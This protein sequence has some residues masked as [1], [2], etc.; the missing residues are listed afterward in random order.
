MADRETTVRLTVEVDKVIVPSGTLQLNATLNLAPAGAGAA[1]KATDS[2]RKKLE[3]MLAPI[4]GQTIAARIGQTFS[5]I[6]AGSAEVSGS[7][8]AVGTASRAC[9]LGFLA[10]AAIVA[11][12]IAVWKYFNWC[13]ETGLRLLTALYNVCKRVA[14]G[15]WNVNRAIVGYIAIPFRAAITGSVQ[16]LEWLVTSGIRATQAVAGLSMEMLKTATTVGAE[17]EQQVANTTTAMGTFGAAGMAMREKIAAAAVAMTAFTATLPTAAAESMWDVASAGFSKFSDLVNV[18]SAAITLAN[19]TLE[20]VSDTGRI[21][22]SILNQYSLATDQAMRVTNALAAA[23]SFSATSVSQLIESMKYAGPIAAAFGMSIEATLA[24]LGVFAQQGILGSQAG[25]ALRNL[26]SNLSAG[27]DKAEKAFRNALGGARALEDTMTA[28]DRAMGKGAMEKIVEQYQEFGAVTGDQAAALA[29]LGINVEDVVKKYESLINLGLDPVAIVELRQ[30]LRG[31]GMDMKSINPAFHSLVEIVQVFEKLQAKLGKQ[32]TVA[33]IGKALNLRAASALYALLNQGSKA[34]ID[35]ERR[36]TGTNMAVQMQRDQLMTLQGQWKILLNLWEVAQ[37]MMAGGMKGALG[38]VVGWLQRLLQTVGQAGMFQRFGQIA[39][40]AIMAIARPLSQL[41]GPA[42]LAVQRI[43]EVFASS[44]PYIEDALWGVVPVMQNFIGQLPALAQTVLASLVN[45]GSW[46]LSVGVPLFTNWVTTV[47]PLLAAGFVNLG[48]TLALFLSQNSGQIIQWF[49]DLLNFGVLLIQFLPSFLPLIYDA[50][51]AFLRWGTEIRNMLLQETGGNF[52]G[53]LVTVRDVLWA[54]LPNIDKFVMTYLPILRAELEALG[55]IGIKFATDTF[56]KIVAAFEKMQPG[57]IELIESITTAVKQ[58]LDA[59]GSFATAMG[60]RFPQIVAALKPIIEWIGNNALPLLKLFVDLLGRKVQLGAID[61]V[62]QLVGL[63]KIGDAKDILGLLVGAG[64]A[65][66]L[67]GEGAASMPP[68]GGA[69]PRLRNMPQEEAISHSEKQSRD[70]YA[71]GDL[72]EG[73]KWE[74]VADRLRKESAQEYAGARASG[75]PVTAGTS[76]MVGERGPELFTPNVGGTITPNG[77][78]GGPFNLSLN[79]TDLHD[80]KA[81][82]NQAI[83]GRIAQS[84]RMQATR[85]ASLAP[86]L[87]PALAVSRVRTPRLGRGGFA[88]D[89]SASPYV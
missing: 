52:T 23:A 36:I 31:V 18:S 77:A 29:N 79:F 53:F 70:A 12:V 87:A 54:L 80:M 59:I 37:L 4:I 73:H 1:A 47:V 48:Y 8:M 84:E 69:R 34:L 19:A 26:L 68:G 17:F 89:F 28:L 32:A 57:L 63:R 82:A 41:A 22:I 64:E 88:A 16:A 6:S 30:Q 43:M 65:V 67:V 40:Q 66:K 72:G 42:I 10:L 46:L 81:A 45:V 78:G 56:P 76:Y 9:V 33:L 50:I 61:I 49:Q 21:L 5:R 51:A 15:I 20:K 39:G 35:M 27:T 11:T 7:I 58:M 74:A 2:L 71:R 83:D 25:T 75:G 85:G 62:K 24:A 60:E 44:L 14:E 55:E 86:A 38:D 13:V 3:D